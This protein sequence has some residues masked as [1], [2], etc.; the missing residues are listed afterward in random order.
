[1]ISLAAWPTVDPAMLVDDQ[2]ELAVQIQG[3]VRCKLTV[4]TG[5]DA[6][7]I[8][9]MALADPEVQKQLAGKAVKKLIVVPGRL[10]NIVAG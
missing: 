7:S 2:I 9:A 1:M 4:P 5:A 6:K 3:K 8:E 10:V